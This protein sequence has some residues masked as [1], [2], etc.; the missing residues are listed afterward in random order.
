MPHAVLNYLFDLEKYY[1]M[2]P[3][4]INDL[5]EGRNIKE[6]FSNIVNGA[7]T[8]IT[9]PTVA[10]LQLSLNSKFLLYLLSYY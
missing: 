5:K 9:Q 7:G 10:F 2:V 6:T 4:E 1:L 3:I 8:I